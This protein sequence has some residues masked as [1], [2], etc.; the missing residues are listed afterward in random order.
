M[1]LELIIIRKLAPGEEITEDK[2]I[3]RFACNWYRDHSMYQEDITLRWRTTKIS[4]ED[5][6]T[7]DQL[8]LFGEHLIEEATK[9]DNYSEDHLLKIV[10]DKEAENLKL[11]LIA[12][13]TTC[14]DEYFEEHFEQI[15]RLELIARVATCENVSDI[16]SGEEIDELESDETIY[17]NHGDLD[18]LTMRR[19]ITFGLDLIKYGSQGYMGYWSY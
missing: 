8:I 10:E 2:E 18:T 12:K 16:L 19:L 13:L 14:S 7:C 15:T 11:K 3:H 9:S 5:V 6:F 17:Y 4:G 1:G